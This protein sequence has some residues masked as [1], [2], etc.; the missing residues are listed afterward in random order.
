MST[1]VAWLACGIVVV[2]TC[3][4]LAFIAPQEPPV[5]HI[6]PP[7]PNLAPK[8]AGLSGMWEAAEGRPGQL[9]VERINETRAV[10]VHSWAAQQ[11]GHPS[12]GWERVMARVQ[13]D[14]SI[15]WGYPVHFTLRLVEDGTTLESQTERAGAVVRTTLKRV[16]ASGSPSGP[17]PQ[18]RPTQ[19]AYQPGEESG[20]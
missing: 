4:V 6:V 10:I 3:L 20:R 5:I 2:G 16:V 15:Q 7:A 13:P 18:A 9:V 17:P 12:G 11:T 19:A 8:L 1:R 14:G